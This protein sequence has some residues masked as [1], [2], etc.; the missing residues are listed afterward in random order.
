MSTEETFDHGGPNDPRPA[1]RPRPAQAQ[2]GSLVKYKAALRKAKR[3]NAREPEIDF[4]NITAMLDLMTIILV[5]L[6]KSLAS[7]AGAIPQ[8]DDLRLPQ[9]V[10]VGEPSDE[11]VL[12]VVSK[13]QILVGDESTAVVSLPSREQMAQSG[14]D[15]KHKRSGPNDLY[16]VP[17]ANAL[18][19][20]R[21]VDKA[22]RAAKGLDPSTSEAR[23]VAD[24]TTP[25]RTLIEVLYTLGQSEFGKYHLMALSGKK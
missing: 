18:Q 25:Y 5:F 12:V 17:L 7:S 24:R 3:K 20:A 1:P 4:L 2:K 16:I 9:S 10:M 23:I 21:E 13:T 8:S 6:L 22:V 11:G 19:H 14:I 15:A